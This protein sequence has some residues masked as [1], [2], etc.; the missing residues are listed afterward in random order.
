[1]NAIARNTV[2]VSAI[3]LAFG[4]FM[5]VAGTEL[6]AGVPKP[7]KPIG[8]A[9]N[10][11]LVPLFQ[12]P[13]LAGGQWDP[14]KEIQDMQMQM[15]KMQ[16]QMD[17]MFNNMS[18]EF[19]GEP[20]SSAWPENSSY[21]LSLNVQDLK[22]RYVVSAFLPDTKVSDV[23]VKLENKQ[24]LQVSV[25]NEQNQSSENK[26]A[27]TSVSEW[28]QYQQLIQLPSPVNASEMKIVRK[29]HELLITLPKA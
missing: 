11:T 13:A 23:H 27:T 24:T 4:V 21:S 3:C 5:G 15:N 17:K 22:N 19:R 12:N 20:Q 25:S 7:E 9:T 26:N 6:K 1:M 2:V 10:Q 29:E 14:Y 8:T 16:A 18:S 28:G